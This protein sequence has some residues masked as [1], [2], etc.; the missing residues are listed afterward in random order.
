[1]TA[2]YPLRLQPYF[3]DYLWGGRQLASELGKNIP[4]TGVWAESWEIVDHPEHS[5]LIVNGAFAGKTLSQV[6]AAEREW[7]LGGYLDSESR[8]TMGGGLDS[9][10]R[11]TLPLLLK[12]L[13]CQRVL[14]VQV[15]PDDSYALR[16]SPPDL[17]KT[18]AWVIIAAQPGAVLYAGLQSGATSA[19]MQTALQAGE[20]E[21]CLHVLHPQAGDCIFIPAGT[22]HALGAGLLVAEIQQASNTTFRLFDW[23]RLGADGQP[24][25]LHV[26]QS[27]E[28][29]DFASGPRRLQTPLPTG[30]AGRERLVACDKFT[31]D[32]LQCSTQSEVNIPVGGDD[33]FHM[34]TVP[35][36]E[37]TLTWDGSSERLTAGQSLLLPA[38]MPA[39]EVRLGGHTVVLD[40]W[41]P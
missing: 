26:A 31:L 3:R 20:V 19:D 6:I 2:A 16:M 40:M 30:Q 37:A 41:L 34:L 36:G 35:S 18:E 25:P 13:D 21:R 4:A 22:V 24:R 38:A 7:L 5:S 10:S 27:L 8:A 17:G 39:S 12:Y 11:A 28:V 32:R 23:N 9:E 33:R 29:I 1:M 14:S 15:H